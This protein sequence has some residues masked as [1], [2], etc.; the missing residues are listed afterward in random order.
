MSKLNGLKPQDL[1]LLEVAELLD[2]SRWFKNFDRDQIEQLAQYF[3]VYQVAKDVQLVSEGETKRFLGIVCSGS[4]LVV[5]ED[6]S[7]KTQE[8]ATL[9]PGKAFGEISL[10]DGFPRSASVITKEPTRVLILLEDSYSRLVEDRARLALQLVENIG[11]IMSARLRQT[12]GRLVD[13]LN[14]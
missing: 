7:G 4:L 2:S 5:K 3:R 13:F 9:G 6:G 12:S 14:G 11:K 8:I 1:E 10:I